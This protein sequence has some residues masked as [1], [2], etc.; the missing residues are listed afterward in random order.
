MPL[1][2]KAEGGDGLFG[3]DDLA[4]GQIPLDDALKVLKPLLEDTA[5][6]KIGQ[7]MKYDTKI[8]SSYGI[9]VQPID[10]TMLMSYAMNAGQHSH[11]MDT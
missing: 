9:D 3:S 6:L 5:V 11:G 10:D 4:E 8:M 7:N 1:T 2:H